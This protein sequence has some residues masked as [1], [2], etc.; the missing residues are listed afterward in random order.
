MVECVGDKSLGGE[1]GFAEVLKFSGVF[2]ISSIQESKR[3][4]GF[5][6]FEF[7]KVW[8]ER[9]FSISISI[10]ISILSFLF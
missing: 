4:L 7:S 1:E 2:S 5:F 3:V 8:R 9:E 10:S 6:Y